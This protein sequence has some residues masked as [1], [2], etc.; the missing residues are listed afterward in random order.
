MAVPGCSVLIS[1]APPVAP[2]LQQCCKA[3]MVRPAKNRDLHGN[4]PDEA[5]VALL[6]IDVINDLELEGGEQLLAPAV[7]MAGPLAGLTR[8]AATPAPRTGGRVPKTRARGG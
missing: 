4:A 6:L 8:R 1:V 2:P 7:A 3:Y 5:R